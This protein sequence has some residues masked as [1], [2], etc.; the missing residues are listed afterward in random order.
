M[1]QAM[2]PS[3]PAA[4]PPPWHDGPMVRKLLMALAALTL[5]ACGGS[6]LV[7]VPQGVTFRVEQTRSGLMSRAIQMQIVNGGSRTLTVSR[8]EFSSKRFDKPV[9]WTGA[10]DDVTLASIDSTVMM[11]F[12]PGFDGEI[13]KSAGAAPLHLDI[14][15]VPTRCDARV[16]AE[17]KAGT[18]FPVHIVSKDSGKAFFR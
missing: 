11:K 5:L 12:A 8:V 9:V 2:L 6:S 15:L 16:V 7:N 18:L 1:V 10:N 17:D 4:R 13:G 3:A 14:P